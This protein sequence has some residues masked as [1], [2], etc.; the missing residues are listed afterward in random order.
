MTRGTCKVYSCTY[1]DCP[2]ALCCTAITALPSPFNACARV[3]VLIVYVCTNVFS[4]LPLMNVAVCMCNAALSWGSTH[5][6]SPLCMLAL[7]SIG[8]RAENGEHIAG[9]LSF[10]GELC[11]VS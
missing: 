11:W 8:Q 10:L 4:A 5:I 1:T 9:T 3:V 6:V 7:P 2:S